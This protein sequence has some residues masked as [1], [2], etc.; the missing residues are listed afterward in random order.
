MRSPMILPL[1]LAC[2]TGSALIACEGEAD[3]A[4][5]PAP[6]AAMVADAG[7][8][9]ADEGEEREPRVGYEILQVVAPDRI[10]TWL[11]ADMTQA[12]FD[13]I[14]LPPGWFKNQPREGEP[15]RGAFARSPDAAR[16]G[17][18]T[19][20]EHFG[21][22]W[23]HVA[24]VVETGIS[25]DPDGLLTGTRVHKY[26]EVGFDAGRNLPVIVSPTGDVY[27]RISRD[28]GRASD[29]PTIPETW[30]AAEYPTDVPLTLQLPERTLVIRADNEDSYQGPVPLDVGQPAPPLP[31]SGE[32]CDDPAAIGA[33][34]DA[35]DRLVA[36]GAINPAQV[37][38]MVAAPTDGP[39]YMVNLIRYRERALYP[40]GR[41]TDLTGREANALYSPVEFLQAIGARVV[42]NTEVDDQID[43]DDAWET[44]AIVEYPCPL[45]FFAM[46]AHPGFQARS[47]HKTAGVAET[48]VMVTERMPVPAPADPDQSQSPHPPTADDPAFDLIHVMDF[49]DEA[50]YAAG[51][52]EPP[53]TG[54]EAWEAYQAGGAEASAALGIYLTGRFVVQGVFIGDA[55]SWDEVVLVHMPSLAGFRALLDDETRR[56]GRHHREAALAHNYSMITYPSLSQIPGSPSGG[57]MQPPPVTADGTGTLCQSDDDCPGGGVDLCLSDS[58]AGFCTREGCAAGGCQAPYVCCRDC[59]PIVQ[60]RL[61]FDGSACLP[62]SVVEQLTAAPA[63]CTCD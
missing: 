39:F 23:T 9:D 20:A 52:D 29:T 2:L 21:H 7:G 17:E 63:S 3:G 11:N 35:L 46:L 30:R 49:H 36:S 42:F 45:A 13:A 1:L 16:D 22:E 31:L 32:L 4:D 8:S 61:P 58:D 6:D 56:E 5:A 60:G 19:V 47:I 24:T 18:F 44:V 55:R 62:A 59:A 26:H 38:R 50:Q 10:V 25:L 27:L 28:A 15:D 14:E 43:G 34:A 33:L 54:R 40:D 51:S 57:G 53:R 12:E 48:I 37:E 41:E